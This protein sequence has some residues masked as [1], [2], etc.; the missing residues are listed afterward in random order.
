MVNIQES[1]NLLEIFYRIP[2]TSVKETSRVEI[3]PS[4]TKI[5]PTLGQIVVFV[6]L[7]G[8]KNLATL[9]H[10]IAAEFKTNYFSAI[11]NNAEQAFEYAVQKVNL[12][13]K[14]NLKD[15]NDHAWIKDFQALLLA[16]FT[17]E[18]HISTVGALQPFIC[19][20]YKINKLG[21]DEEKTSV[22]YAKMFSSII[23]GTLT[24]RS[25]L[26]IVNSAVQDYI[27][28]ERLK[29]I[30]LDAEVPFD[31]NLEQLLNDARGTL[32]FF[33]ACLKLGEGA[34]AH[35][36]PRGDI[37]TL[38]APQN[39]TMSRPASRGSTAK[40]L[41]LWSALFVTKQAALCAQVC[42]KG[43]RNLTNKEYRSSLASA[44]LRR[45][46]GRSLRFSLGVNARRWTVVC[47]VYIILICI[48][49][50]FYSLSSSYYKRQD[51]RQLNIF[52]TTLQSLVEQK[53][54]AESSLIYNDRETASLLSESIAL[55]LQNLE[56]KDSN[57]QEQKQ[58]LVSALNALNDKINN[59]QN[60][61]TLTTVYNDTSVFS[62]TK[63]LLKDGVVGMVNSNTGSIKP[64]PNQK[65]PSLQSY[66]VPDGAKDYEL[67]NDRVYA[68]LPA[69]NTIE[70]RD[71]KWNT[72]SDD[73]THATHIA[74]DGFVYTINT[75]GSI[76]KWLKG[77]K[78][79]TL[80]IQS[81]FNAAPTI[82]Y[83][84]DT[85]KALYALDTHQGRIY[86]LDKNGK[87]LRQIQNAMFKEA[88]DLI[89]N[90]KAN[91]GYIL[92]SHDVKSF[93]LP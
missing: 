90:E 46:I 2:D 23:S 12:A 69:K 6:K 43:V 21:D 29:K 41:V 51:S 50:F 13:L 14:A 75:N 20:G 68:L 67:Y 27:S 35:Y 37:V 26:V 89:V 3:H 42:V 15:H 65:V 64:L 73:V 9:P 86:A 31:K 80:S 4:P 30:A 36:A 54:K 18:V 63:L 40:K 28:L 49:A 48:A 60:V 84:D 17:D 11:V 45:T 71:K 24:S 7:P 53:N 57:Q 78:E 93:K 58:N 38:T 59:V 79:S 72:G 44:L 66:T 16:S 85:S 1:N 70:T 34:I 22:T 61:D 56:A 76:D 82:I 81:S 39:T 33:G 92:T 52:E 83:T 19:Q 91:L 74:I 88:L 32:T 5:D 87:L 77:R 47:S 8:K 62:P 55:S 10:L 25:A